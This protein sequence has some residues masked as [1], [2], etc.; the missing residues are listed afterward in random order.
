MK[1]EQMSR[2]KRLRKIRRYE[3]GKET[4]TRT[5]LTEMAA[6]YDVPPWSLCLQWD[7]DLKQLMIS[8]RWPSREAI[9]EA[10]ALYAQ[11]EP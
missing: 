4:P 11:L 10:R 6:V 8:G 5:H 7:D 3:A 9:A 2:R 1:L